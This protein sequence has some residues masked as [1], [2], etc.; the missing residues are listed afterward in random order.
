MA[1]YFILGLIEIFM[2]CFNEIKLRGMG[3][4][5]AVAGGL[6]VIATAQV[7]LPPPASR[8]LRSRPARSPSASPIRASPRPGGPLLQP[9]HL[10]RRRRQPAWEPQPRCTLRQL[11][12]SPTRLRSGDKGRGSPAPEHLSAYSDPSE[13]GVPGGNTRE[14]YV[15]E[16]PHSHPLPHPWGH[17]FSPHGDQPPNLEHQDPEEWTEGRAGP[18]ASPWSSREVEAS[19]RPSASAA[20][21]LLATAHD[22]R[23]GQL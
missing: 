18:R 2:L 20:V 5:A 10:G 14:G 11:A 19:L 7:F 21:F 13:S 9:A 22:F 15:A 3:W 8:E 6:K 17:P 12:P 23:G 1:S 16:S 4:E